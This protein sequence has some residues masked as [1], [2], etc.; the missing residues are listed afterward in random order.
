M[1]KLIQHIPI[2][3]HYLRRLFT[4]VVWLM[5][6][7]AGGAAL[8]AAAATGV[9]PN[10]SV[11]LTD[12]GLNQVMIFDTATV[13]TQPFYVAGRVEWVTPF[14]NTS[15]ALG[16]DIYFGVIMPGGTTVSTWSP[17]NSGT[18]TLGSGYAPLVRASSVL[19]TGVLTTASLNAG[20]DI[21]Y[22]FSGNEPKGLYL[23]FL[24]MVP[25]GADPTDIQRWTF[26]T[27]QPF[28]VK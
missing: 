7:L 6:V 23:L 5:L 16:A 28:F 15:W 25:T 27:T 19:N 20:K 24:F 18:V 2:S 12:A 11:S 13:G 8:P 3:A 26:L 21:S 17:N 9:A 4:R 10:V 1:F 14:T 22:R